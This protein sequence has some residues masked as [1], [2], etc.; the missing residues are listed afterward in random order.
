MQVQKSNVILVVG[1]F[2]VLGLYVWGH[3][4]LS[5]ANLVDGYDAPPAADGKWVPRESDD[6]SLSGM[7]LARRHAQMEKDL[8]MAAIFASRALQHD[9]ENRTLTEDTLRLLVAAGE[10]GE[11]VTLAKKLNKKGSFS[12]LSSMVLMIEHVKRGEFEAARRELNAV[13]EHSTEGGFYNMIKPVFGLWVD[14]GAGIVEG[15]SKTN[16]SLKENKFLDSFVNYQLALINDMRG[17]TEKAKE[18]YAKSTSR[19]TEMPY[20]LVQARS[21]FYLRQG[22]VEKAKA[23]YDAYAQVNPSSRLIP[24]KV[25]DINKLPDQITPLVSSVQEGVAEVFFTTASLLFTEEAMRE[26]LVYLRLALYLRPDF[27]PAQMMLANLE[28]YWK[29]H[30][31]AIATYEMIEPGTVFYKR[32]MIRR[33]LNHELLEQ[34]DKA[35]RLLQRFVE[36][37]PNDDDAFVSLGDIHRSK[38]RYRQA[39]VAYSEAIDR[40][41]G[42][43]KEEHWRLY[44]VRGTSYEQ[45]KEWEQAEKD[46]MF[47][48]ELSPQQPDVLNYLG[49]S[50]LLAGKNVQKAKTYIE[51]A[52]AAEP[53]EAH[54]IDSMGW[55]Y[56]ITGEFEEAVGYLE[57]A[58]NMVPQDATINEHLGDAYWRAGR[59]VEAKFQWKRALSFEPDDAQS[60]RDKIANG[61][62]PFE[63]PDLELFK[64]PKEEV[65]QASEQMGAEDDNSGTKDDE[66]VAAVENE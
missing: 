64:A 56:Y 58:T 47:A 59:R 5:V 18:Y 43:P 23:P 46:L 29:N 45:A 19:P 63:L 62:P 61:M 42:E 11:A 55:A 41:E 14:V 65:P 53:F 35:L 9:P 33:A 50:W 48:L 28:E 27:P 60:L 16:S 40:I 36:L 31:R 20:R 44:Y 51:E 6:T 15:E 2:A 7:Y 10:M 22:E 66:P 24:D 17:F 21:N 37:Y 32:G 4:R 1:A 52:L 30:E 49:Y 25:P 34:P 3:D 54:I 38:K 12:T 26:T 39:I 57:Q 13:N 8:N